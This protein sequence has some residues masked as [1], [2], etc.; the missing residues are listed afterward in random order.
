MIDAL[1][2]F[3]LA[4]VTISTLTVLYGFAKKEANKSMANHIRLEMKK[5]DYEIGI[6]VDWYWGAI[7]SASFSDDAKND[8]RAEFSNEH[9]RLLHEKR[10]LEKKLHELELR[11]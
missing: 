2:R 1:T 10:R 11:G 8:V 7:L 5:I 4:G 9:R 3:A 6:L